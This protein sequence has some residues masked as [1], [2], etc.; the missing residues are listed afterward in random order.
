[1]GEAQ[2]EFDL[3]LTELL[4]AEDESEQEA[5]LAEYATEE[6]AATDP[7]SDLDRARAR[8]VREIGELRDG[9]DATPAVENFI[10]IIMQ[11]LK[12]GIRLIG[13]KRVVNFLGGLL[14]K[15]I[16]PLTGKDLAPGLGKIIAACRVWCRRTS[17]R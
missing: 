17:R 10:P 2:S 11:A 6:V 1:V 5:A 8:F 12:I 7:L 3:Q 16:S 4:L 14:G 9:E 13:R 15:L